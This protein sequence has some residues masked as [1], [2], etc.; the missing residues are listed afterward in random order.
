MLLVIEIPQQ[1]HIS[2]VHICA[3]VVALAVPALAQTYSIDILA[4]RMII[5]FDVGEVDL[6][7]SVHPEH[8][9]Q[10]VYILRLGL[11]VEYYVL[12]SIVNVC[13]ILLL[14]VFPQHASGDYYSVVS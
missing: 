2:V 8:S 9:A 3:A 10:I 14:K 5:L 12:A 6:D 4:R 7:I 1:E 13:I 11:L